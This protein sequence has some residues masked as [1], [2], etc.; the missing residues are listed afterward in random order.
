[1]SAVTELRLLKKQHETFKKDAQKL[2][3]ERLKMITDLRLAV[4]GLLLAAKMQHDAIDKLFSEV[5]KR[6]RKYQPSA[7]GLPWEAMLKANAA[8]AFGE[9]VR[10]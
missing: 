5:V 6:D 10:L 1:M 9:R 4:D 7:S 8:I 3:D 2:M